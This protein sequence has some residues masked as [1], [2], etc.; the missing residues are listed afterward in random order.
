MLTF[1]STDVCPGTERAPSQGGRGPESSFRASEEEALRG[2]LPDL[3][4]G[5]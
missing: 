2:K 4:L 1:I 3:K 5:S